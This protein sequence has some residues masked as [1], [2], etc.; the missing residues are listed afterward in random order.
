VPCAAT[1]RCLWDWQALAGW[2]LLAVAS[3]ACA[4]SGWRTAHHSKRW[5]C[6]GFCWCW[7]TPDLLPAS[8]KSAGIG[9]L[10]AAAQLREAPVQRVAGALHITQ[11][12]GFV[13]TFVGVAYT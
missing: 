11:R 1:V 13:L 9:R 12:G 10:V 6:V 5:L 7:L 2:L 3:G 4:A 8:A